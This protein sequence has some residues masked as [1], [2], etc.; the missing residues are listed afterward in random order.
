MPH[1]VGL[2]ISH[3][4]DTQIPSQ[5]LFSKI[6]GY[7]GVFFHKLAKQRQS[8]IPEEHLCK[9]HVQMYIVIPPKYSDVQVIGFMKGKSAT[10]IARELKG[11]ARGYAGQSFWARGY[12]V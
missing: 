11:R 12:I 9:D 4:L 2:Q 5:D 6:R 1:A 10:H 8:K 7:L 3:H